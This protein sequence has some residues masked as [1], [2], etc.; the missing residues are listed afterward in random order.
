MNLA[1]VITGDANGPP[2]YPCGSACLI[3]DNLNEE[4]YNELRSTFDGLKNA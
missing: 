2:P 1:T 4:D 3:Y